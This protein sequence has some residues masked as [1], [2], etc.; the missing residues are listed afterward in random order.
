[1]TAKFPEAL[2]VYT[3]ALRHAY[4]NVGAIDRQTEDEKKEGF[5]R[6]DITVMMLSEFGH[7]VTVNDD[8][9][10]VVKAG[11]HFNLS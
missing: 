8:G 10:Y 7:E 11:K 1:M 9:T 4:V 2:K 6:L 3:N 5:H